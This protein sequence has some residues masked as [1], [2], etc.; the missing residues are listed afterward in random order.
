M[1]LDED[2]VANLQPHVVVAELLKVVTTRFTIRHVHR[3]IFFL[4]W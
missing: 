2:T 3:D 4:L 1:G